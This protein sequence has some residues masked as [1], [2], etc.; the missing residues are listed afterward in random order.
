MF[1][2]LRA[3]AVLFSAM[4]MFSVVSV[5]CGAQFGTDELYDALPPDAAE[6]LDESGIT[7]EGG[8]DS[9][10]VSGILETIAE[11]VTEN[12]EKPPRPRVKSVI[13]QFYHL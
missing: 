6:M 12:A 4:I 9:V 1:K 2:L 7:P 11:L 5:Q 3:F 8:A 13:C 10:K